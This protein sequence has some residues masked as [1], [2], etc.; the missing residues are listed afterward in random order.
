[1]RLKM[2]KIRVKLAAKI[3][4]YAGFIILL[5]AL[6]ISLI[7]LK[8][9]SNMLL[10]AEE[11]SIGNIAESGAAQVKAEIERRLGVLSETAN[12]INITSSNWEMKRLKL[13]DVVKRLGYMDMALVSKDGIAQYIVNDGTANLGDREYVKKAMAG[14]ANVSDVIASQVTNSSVIMYAAPIYQNNEI[15]GVLIGRADGASLNEITDKLSDDERGF[16]FIIGADSTFYA[17]QDR[18][19]VINQVNA[20]EQIELDG[21]FKDFGMKLKELGLGNTGI[22]KYEYEG[23]KRIAALHPIEGT[24]WVLGVS[25]YEKDVL[26]DVNRLRNYI[27]IT[28]FIVMAL[29]IGAGAF[30]GIM[31]ARPILKLQS[32][33]EVISHYDLTEDL[34]KNHANI[35]KRS[36]EI[37]K[38]AESLLTMKSNI[39]NLVKTVAMNAEHIASS[40][41]ELS[42]ITEHT[43]QSANEVAKTIEDIAKGASDQAK[44]TENGAMST[45]TLGNLITENQSN[46]DE[47]NTSINTV[48]GLSDSGL[49]AIQ[50]LNERNIESQNASKEIYNMVVETDKSADR[51]K[52]A[53]E[54]IKSIADQTN[55]L[56]LNA[57]IEAAR[58]GEAG[59]GFAVVADEIRKL[60]EQSNQFTDEISGIIAELVKNTD[61]CVNV[62]DRVEKIMKL[63]TASVD[64]T[65][66]KFNGIHEAI[67]N[68]RT[69]I[70]KLNVSGQNM[71]TSKEDLIKVMENLSAIAQQNAA[72]TEEA[73]ASIEVQTNSITEIANASES[74]AELAQELQAEISKFK[75]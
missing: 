39:L 1:M 7:S 30:I 36:D 50:D 41:E 20:F 13:M 46:L 32:S 40:S 52:K 25:S 22:I 35:L 31:L 57:S 34:S 69:I 59:R 33:L 48:N 63:Q 60:A 53:S 65:I 29:G 16:A 64:N 67:V 27:L 17:H 75:Y 43:N 71:N 15:T 10:K 21:P 38:I 5:V 6:A 19:N 45:S 54:M 47:L 12:N 18:E 8:Y 14:E 72:G 28:F 4:L 70:E 9:S 26:K 24:P 74:L 62:F 49:V 73:S 51:I 66:D 58:A 56:A 55:L 42:S 44:Q 68:I 2:P 23:D 61:A 37:G 11:K 3:G